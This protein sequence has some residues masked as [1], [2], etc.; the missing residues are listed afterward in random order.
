MSVSCVVGM[1]TAY[2]TDCGTGYEDDTTDT[3]TGAST[4]LVLMEDLLQA[5]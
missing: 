2:E 5:M 1:S 3:D 4:S